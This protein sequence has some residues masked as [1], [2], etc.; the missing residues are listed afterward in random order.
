MEFRAEQLKTVSEFLN[1]IAVAW[2][3][4]GIITPLFVD[5]FRLNAMIFVSVFETLLFL[6]LSL[7]L[8]RDYDRR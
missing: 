5:S 4:G 8:I 1:M 6:I 3:T 2:F 7:Y